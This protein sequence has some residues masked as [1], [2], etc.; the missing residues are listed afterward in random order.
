[1]ARTTIVLTDELQQKARDMGVNVS[2]VSRIAVSDAVL[3]A[4][5]A[6]AYADQM[7][8]VFVWDFEEA[9]TAAFTGDRSDPPR[10]FRGAR[11]LTEAEIIDLDGHFDESDDWV[12][13]DFVSEAGRFVKIANY[14]GYPYIDDV[15]DLTVDDAVR[16]RYLEQLDRPIELSL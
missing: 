14:D 8:D 16:R 3:Q 13:R 5:L 1:V 12:S 15:S 2:E 6:A 7:E 9:H 4:E 10:V 11:I